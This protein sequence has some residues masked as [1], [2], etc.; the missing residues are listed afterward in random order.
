MG[1]AIFLLT[2]GFLIQLE[3][4]LHPVSSDECFPDGSFQFDIAH[5][6]ATSVSLGLRLNERLEI[7][8]FRALEQGVIGPVEAT[9]L[10]QIGDQLVAI[11]GIDLNHRDFETAIQIIQQQS[12]SSMKNHHDHHSSLQIRIQPH[13]ARC[14][15]STTMASNVSSS[16]RTSGHV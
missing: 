7:I 8:E 15:L 9:G 3:I 16:V 6:P 10:A 2:I 13:D 1:L 14:P 11:N 5:E 4:I 12:G